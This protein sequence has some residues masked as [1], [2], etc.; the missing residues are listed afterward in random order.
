MRDCNCNPFAE[1]SPAEWRETKR[2]IVFYSN[3][4]HAALE[5]VVRYARTEIDRKYAIN[6]IPRSV[7]PWRMPDVDLCDAT[8]VL[9][10][11][12]LSKGRESSGAE[13]IT[14][15]MFMVDTDDVIDGLC[16]AED[17][18]LVTDNFTERFGEDA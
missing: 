17:L 8:A 11:H 4:L 13:M 5:Q 7:L 9:A 10:A 15:A 2:T 16:V 1:Q 14:N 3:D 18:A 6:G 12:Y